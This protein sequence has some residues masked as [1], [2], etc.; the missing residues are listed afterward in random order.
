MNDFV[1]FPLKVEVAAGK[2]VQVLT[3]WLADP[4]W[5]VPRGDLHAPW[6]CLSSAGRPSEGLEEEAVRAQLEEVEEDTEVTVFCHHIVISTQTKFL[7]STPATWHYYP[8]PVLLFLLQTPFSGRHKGL[9]ASISLCPLSFVLSH[10]N[11]LHVLLRY[12]HES[13]LWTSSS[14]LFFLAAHLHCPLYS[15]LLCRL[16]FITQSWQGFRG[17]C[18]R[19]KTV[20]RL[21]QMH[22]VIEPLCEVR[23]LNA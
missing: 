8:T 12:I 16:T 22:S 20:G 15:T 19:V 2:I 3:W 13:T 1:L 5:K 21:K 14:L 11:P 4:W 9:V 10:T 23:W 18:K 7:V 17:T 6:R